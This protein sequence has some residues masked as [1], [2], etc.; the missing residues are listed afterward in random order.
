MDY[1]E[2][3]ILKAAKRTGVDEKHALK[4]IFGLK[5]IIDGVP[6][7]TPNRGDHQ[8]AVELLDRF[9]THAQDHEYQWLTTAE[10]LRML[11]V[12]EPSHSQGIVFGMV[13]KQ[14]R[15]WRTKRSGG[16]KLIHFPPV[17]GEHEVF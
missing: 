15:G 3:A 16:K 17:L 1:L 11:G 9:K 12:D 13:V 4:I 5:Q 2:K 14:Q 6:E 10:A 7:Q 8:W